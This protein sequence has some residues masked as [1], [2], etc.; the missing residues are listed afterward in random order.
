[1]SMYTAN[2]RYEI[3]ANNHFD[4]KVKELSLS[5]FNMITRAMMS[6]VEL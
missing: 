2:D 1:M 5:E 4:N 3:T 6:K